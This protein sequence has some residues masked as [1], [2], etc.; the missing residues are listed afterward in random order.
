MTERGSVRGISLKIQEEERERRMDFVP[1]KSALD[2]EKFSIDA[3]TADLLKS[4][5]FGDFSAMGV[6]VHSDQQNRQQ[7]HN[8]RS[9][10][11]QN[12]RKEKQQ[13]S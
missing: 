9:Q 4:I 10:N 7:N 3:D 11:R 8:Q 1:D 13:Q 6:E 5:D 12:Q 2:V